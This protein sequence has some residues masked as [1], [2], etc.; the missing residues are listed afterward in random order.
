M[1]GKT[2][3][4]DHAATTP[5]CK[6][7]LEKMI[8]FFTDVFGNPNSQHAFGREAVK[9]VD[10]ARDDIAKI[11]NAKA[12]EVYFT[13]GGTEGDN[14]A[15]RGIAHAYQKKGKH[16]II[17]PIEHAAMLATAKALS[18]EGKVIVFQS[19]SLHPN[20]IGG[21]QT[22]PSIVYELLTAESG[23][24][25]TPSLPYGICGNAEAL[26]LQCQTVW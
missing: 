22:V 2:I 17:S 13:S 12:S 5:V 8:P 15:L 20:E 24:R 16:I 18:K 3:Y 7:A 9:A 10:Q 19:Y 4:F 1:N 21:S 26:F 23:T 14:W 11:I 6:E 25:T